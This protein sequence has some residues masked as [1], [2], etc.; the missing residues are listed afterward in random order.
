[1]KQSDIPGPN[2]LADALERLRG[3]P[4]I[5]VCK[6]SRDDV[7]RSGLARLIVDAYEGEEAQELPRFITGYSAAVD[8][9][10][11]L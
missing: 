6:F 8:E 3:I 7:V 2:G 9:T 1:M 4:S 11:H 10:D 5:G